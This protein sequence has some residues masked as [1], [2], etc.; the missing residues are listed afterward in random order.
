MLHMKRRGEH[1]GEEIRGC[2]MVI[3]SRKANPFEAY[4]GTKRRLINFYSV[5][6]VELART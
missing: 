2:E 1:V 3:F 4:Q 6:D 5:F